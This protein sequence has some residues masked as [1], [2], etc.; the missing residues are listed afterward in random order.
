MNLL[1][2]DLDRTITK[3]DNLTRFSYYMLFNEKKVK[4]IIFFP[5]YLL[6]KIKLISNIT[7][8]VLYSRLIIKNLDFDSLN[9]YSNKFVFTNSFQNDLNIDV[10]EFIASY[11]GV[12]KIIISANFSFLVQSIAYHLKIHSH[13]S[14]NIDVGNN[15]YTGRISGIIPY[16]HEKISALKN[17]LEGKSYD[18][19][20]GLGDGT[21]DL[22][23][24]N[25]LDEG[26]LVKYNYKTKK[27]EIQPI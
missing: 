6:L 22:P 18:R 13:I 25:Y 12:D 20:I 4:F 24:L 15:K 9:L 11:G 3:S 16:G 5:L 7:F 10:S 26:Y 1:V 27:T 21:S 23:I 17:Y 14:I 8:K 19:Y 2:L